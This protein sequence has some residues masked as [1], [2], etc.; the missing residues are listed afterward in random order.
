MTFKFN[1]G[2][3][4]GNFVFFFLL[5]FLYLVGLGMRLFRSGLHGIALDSTSFLEFSYLG[6]GI[7]ASWYVPNLVGRRIEVTESEIKLVNRSGRVIKSRRFDEISKLK[8]G[9]FETPP[10]NH[11]MIFADG[12]KWLVSGY[13]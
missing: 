7:W 9:T 2:K 10:R 4:L 3:V 13:C 8:L 11:W 12:K 6:M 1:K 5:A